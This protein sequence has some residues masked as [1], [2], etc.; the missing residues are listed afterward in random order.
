[1]TIRQA[2]GHKDIKDNPKGVK[3]SRL[4]DFNI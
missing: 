2:E 1:V 3:T 4:Y